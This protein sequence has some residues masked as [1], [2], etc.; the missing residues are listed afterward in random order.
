MI[1]I[2]VRA[3]DFGT[4]P[5]DRLAA[6]VAIPGVSCIQ[7]ALSKAV[8]GVEK[9]PAK[10]GPEGA[11][12][13]RDEFSRRG[14]S[15][16]VLGCYINPVHPDPTSREA[17]LRRFEDHLRAAADFGCRIVGTETGSIE[18]DCSFHPDTAKESTYL[19]LR[20]G[21][22]RLAK[23]AESTGPGGAIVGV[24]AVSHVH[25]ISSAALMERLLKEVDS[26]AVGVI[27][28]PVNLVPP[29]GV[30]SQDDFLD[31]CFAAFGSRIV[32][33]HAKDFRMEEGCCGLRKVHPLPA[34][35][36]EMDWTGVFRRL[37]ASGKESVPVLLENAGPAD[38]PGAIASLRDAWERSS[39]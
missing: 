2:G 25:T 23:A 28:D 34:G 1:T 5:P 18:P 16:A 4:L 3:H 36:G 29:T 9:D 39:R 27:F 6:E 13:I 20:E 19:T 10:L 7:L 17:A 35:T 8:S 31:E 12:A 22:R 11:R 14:V 38:A 33:I 32:A 30:R 24:E 15:V 37:R 21:V 26:S